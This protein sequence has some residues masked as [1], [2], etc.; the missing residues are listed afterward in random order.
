MKLPQGAAPHV[1]FVAFL[2]QRSHY[3]RFLIENQEKYLV[4]VLAIFCSL[5]KS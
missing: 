2:K 1:Y 5:K 3:I 4:V